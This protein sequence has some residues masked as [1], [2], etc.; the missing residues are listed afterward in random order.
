[1]GPHRR[2][3]TGQQHREQAK[4]STGLPQAGGEAARVDRGMGTSGEH[5]GLEGVDN[6][7]TNA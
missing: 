5:E 4:A 3:G 6:Q 7:N 1:M 2:L